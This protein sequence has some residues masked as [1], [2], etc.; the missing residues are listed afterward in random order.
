[1][2]FISS[3][4]KNR[5]PEIG[6]F[7]GYF[8]YVI[9]GYLCLSLALT[10]NVRI[11]AIDTLFTVVSAIF[12]T[13]LCIVNIGEQYNLLGQLVILILIQVGGI[14]YMTFGSFIVLS[15]KK[16]MSDHRKKIHETVLVCPKNSASRNLFPVS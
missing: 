9:L 7:I 2:R 1:M 8:S 10:R 3:Y 5:R 12:T 11:P 6:L 4:L 15:I 14:G 16:R 13:G